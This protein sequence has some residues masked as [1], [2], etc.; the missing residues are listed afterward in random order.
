MT[1]FSNMPDLFLPFKFTIN[2]GM[3]YQ[4]IFYKPYLII[5]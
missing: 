1:I 4:H 2:K 3:P 5:L